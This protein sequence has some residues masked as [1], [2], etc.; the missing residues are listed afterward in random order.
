MVP[1]FLGGTFND[2]FVTVNVSGSGVSPQN[3]GFVDANGY[4]ETT[5]Q[6]SSSTVAGNYSVS[7][8]DSGGP[9]QNSL[10]FTVIPVITGISPAQSF[11]GQLVTVTINGAGFVSGA[12]IDAGP[13]ISVSNIS[14]TSSTQLTAYFAITSSTSAVGDQGVTVK[15]NGQTSNTA[16][17]TVNAR[18][19]AVAVHFA[20]Q[21]TPGDNLTFSRASQQTCSE[22]LGL[23]NCSSIGTWVWNVEVQG[24]VNDSAGAWTFAQSY[25]GRKKGFTRDSSGNLVP[26]DISLNVPD[27]GPGSGFVQ[28]PS[29]QKIM[30]FIDG[31]G[32]I[33]QLNGQPIDSITQV[34]NFTIKTCSL[35]TTG[36]CTITNWYF[37]LVVNPG[38]VLDTAN[39][40]AAIGIAA[41]AF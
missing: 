37:K 26:F 10:T 1:V 39:S 17:F 12:S 5:F 8:Q 36:V 41:T 24:T 32:H 15:V 13:N 7:V 29:G 16:K 14:V 30:F 19:A 31:P 33:Y 20:G 27:D 3:P 11:P 34:E 9:S 21:K 6:L 18:T 23:L 28:Q 40:V 2:T 22:N 38:A 25:T 35:V 4:V